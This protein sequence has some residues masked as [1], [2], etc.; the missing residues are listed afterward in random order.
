MDPILIEL[1]KASPMAAVAAWGLWFITTTMRDELKRLRAEIRSLHDS[2]LGMLVK[3]W[4]R[5]NADDP[6]SP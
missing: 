1:A 4:K 2:I 3:G 6:E 5:E